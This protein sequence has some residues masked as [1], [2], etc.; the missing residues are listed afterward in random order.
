[1]RGPSKTV[2]FEGQQVLMLDLCK[3]FGI[4]P[5]RAYSRL[6]AGWS[7][8]K[9]FRTPVDARK[10]RQ[11][12]EAEALSVKP[13]KPKPKPKPTP[14]APRHNP[15]HDLR[16][17]EVEAK[18]KRAAALEHAAPWVQHPQPITDAH[19]LPGPHTVVSAFRAGVE[20]A[21]AVAIRRT[22]LIDGWPRVTLSA[23]AVEQY[24][25]AIDVEALVR[26]F[27]P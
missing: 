4:A 14:P 24:L 20:R 8:E 7:V 25:R 13:L 26:G 22:H 12:T 6:W 2:E 11:L 21:I 5:G 18:I 15:S 3:R 16:P 10:R 23:A 9:T 19:P 17:G 1:M 27:R